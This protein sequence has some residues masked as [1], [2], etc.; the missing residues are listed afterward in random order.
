MTGQLKL[1]Q[2]DIRRK[3]TANKVLPNVGLKIFD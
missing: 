2:Y 1:G 3:N